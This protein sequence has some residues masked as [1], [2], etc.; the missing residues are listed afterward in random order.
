MAIGMCMKPCPHTG[1]VGPT[2]A[3][4]AGFSWLGWA[5][6]VELGCADLWRNERSLIKYDLLAQL[7]SVLSIPRT[8]TSLL[9]PL[10]SGSLAAA[11]AYY[12]GL[13]ALA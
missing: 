1:Q 9:Q 10:F 7:F 6:P 12:F 3:G 4:W 2:L 13:L 8:Y 11:S 5:L